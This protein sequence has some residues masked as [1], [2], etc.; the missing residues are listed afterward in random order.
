MRFSECWMRPN[1][2]R[3]NLHAI[4]IHPGG[5]LTLTLTLQQCTTRDKCLT[6]SGIMLGLKYSTLCHIPYLDLTCTSNFECNIQY[7]VPPT[8]A[9]LNMLS[10]WRLQRH[11]NSSEVKSMTDFAISPPWDKP[12]V[13]GPNQEPRGHAHL[14]LGLA[15]SSL[16]DK[17]TINSPHQ[18]PWR[19]ACLRGLGCRARQ[20][21]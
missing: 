17:P 5:S 7:H 3:C 6:P 21:C 13:N 8:T 1:M 11:V 10:V 15:I 19:Q 18:E 20:G 14:R 16:R 9:K 12:T 2:R 4:I